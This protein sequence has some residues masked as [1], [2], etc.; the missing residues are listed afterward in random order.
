MQPPWRFI[1][2]RRTKG[3]L[4]RLFDVQVNDTGESFI[5]RFRLAIKAEHTAI[6]ILF[7]LRL[8]TSSPPYAEGFLF[9]GHPDDLGT[10]PWLGAEQFALEINGRIVALID[11]GYITAALRST[12][13]N[14][15]SITKR[16]PDLTAPDTA[17]F[18][19]ARSIENRPVT[20]E[21]TYPIADATAT[22][23]DVPELG[24]V[25][26]VVEKPPALLRKCSC[27]ERRGN[28][29]GSQKPLC[30]A[31]HID[32]FA[33]AYMP[34]HLG[35]NDKEPVDETHPNTLTVAASALYWG[36]RPWLIKR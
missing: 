3:S 16:K 22:N 19:E 18:I 24:I 12:A 4:S 21:C 28:K 6:T 31:V 9:I 30:N 29:Q 15:K 35:S 13:G 25:V 5:V 2:R 27:A 32:T 34:C 1:L 10:W 36:C 14:S 20:L 33:R 26:I 8:T 23:L 11:R 17:K 7:K